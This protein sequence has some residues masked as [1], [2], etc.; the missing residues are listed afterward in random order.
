MDFYRKCKRYKPK[1]SGKTAEYLKELQKEHMPE[2][3][4][5]GIIQAW[6]DNYKDDYVAAE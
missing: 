5:V 3:T 4:N 6:L 1:L 2:D